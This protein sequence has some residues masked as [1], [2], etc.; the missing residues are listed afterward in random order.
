MKKLRVVFLYVFILFSVVQSGF[1][2]L[3]QD[4]NPDQSFGA[5]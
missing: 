2:L 4:K 3:Q 5:D 1:F